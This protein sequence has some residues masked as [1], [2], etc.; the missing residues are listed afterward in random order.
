MFKKGPKVRLLSD[1]CKEGVEAFMLFGGWLHAIWR[2]P[3]HSVSLVSCKKNYTLYP[4]PQEE[5]AMQKSWAKDADSEVTLAHADV[6]A[7]D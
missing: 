1:S 6:H 2:V 3:P 5:V 4:I 7:V